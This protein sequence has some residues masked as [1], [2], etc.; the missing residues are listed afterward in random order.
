MKIILGPPGTGKTQKLLD[1]IDLAIED[2]MKPE[3]IGFLAFTRKAAIEAKDR[4]KIKFNL[5]DTKLTYFRTIHSLAFRQLSLSKTQIMQRE[6]YVELG[7]A[8]GIA[9]TGYVD[10]SEGSL[11]YGMETGDRLIFLD[12][13]AR[14]KRVPLR[15]VWENCGSDGISWFELV[16]TSDAIKAYKKA[17]GLFDFTDI[18]EMFCQRGYVP[19]LDLLVIDEA[20]DLSKLQWEVVHRL[21]KSANSVIVAG[22]DDQSIFS[23]SGADTDYFINLIGEV[24]NLEVSWRVP[25]KI[26]DLA[27]DIVK[28]ISNR[29]DK[30]WVSSKEG[31]GVHWH[32]DIDT[33][34]L[35]EGNWLILARNGYM[36]KQVEDHCMLSGFS[37]AGRFSPLKS[38]TLT[39]IRL[40]E[41]LR[42]GDSITFD[43]AKK[44]LALM[45][46][47]IDLRQLVG[48]DKIDMK[49]LEVVAYVK[50]TRKIWHEA[51]DRI[52][53][54]EREY[55]IA[56]RRAGETLVKTPRISVSTIHG[57]K[58][59]ESDNVLLFTDLA[60]RTYD[61][62]INRPDDEH[63]VFYVGVTR[64]K[65][66]LHLIQPRTNKAF[67]I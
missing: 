66:D 3:K 63:R 37:F 60:P 51:L 8:L 26:Q 25:S 19:E 44:V 61:E 36:L 54:Y 38:P 5:P 31:G 67:L 1:M 2:G 24:Q 14:T 13:L 12:G 43:Q 52:P 28:G 50:N 4:A 11:S 45:N 27:L 46:Q 32:N 58:G 16:R 64:A 48:F 23:W 41:S 7:K 55:F 40:W 9:V 17:R 10:M 35:N 56:A 18:L 20:Q 42:K 30:T 22:D 57:A 34:P 21:I 39:S 62:F 49:T 47:R 53:A 65:Q 6:N 59:G 33:V 29:R 15:D